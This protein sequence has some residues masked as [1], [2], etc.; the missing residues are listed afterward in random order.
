M[1]AYVSFMAEPKPTKISATQMKQ[2][3]VLEGLGKIR[4]LSVGVSNYRNT[5][6]FSVIKQC[7]SDALNVFNAFRD[8]K[9][10]NAH[11]DHQVLLTSD[12]TA[13][14][15][16]RGTIIHEL[17]DLAFKSEENDRLMFYFS[18]HGQRIQGID[19]HFLAPEDVYAAD[20]P[21]AMISMTQ[22]KE[23]LEKAKA[24]Q[25][26]IVLDSCLGGPTG[27]GP[28]LHAASYSDKFF[29][30]YLKEMKGFAVLTSS[31]SNEISYA[32]SD[33]PELSLFTFF[34]VK[35]LRGE[36][37]ALDDQ[38]LTLPKLFD[39]VGTEVQRKGRSYHIQQTPS[40]DDV[41]LAVRLSSRIL[42]DH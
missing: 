16:S 28:K 42:E 35:A 2:L 11:T 30:E 33:N 19:D 7:S 15:P 25:K 24:K 3:A 21:A 37:E 8:I 38:I 23:I 13:Q 17:R 29:A 10:L 1:T 12:T 31:A 5:S 14:L 4:L 39:Y 34:F 9:Q 40:L 26:I 27:L 36:P 6:G 32:Q 20:D 41:L 18:G 22:V